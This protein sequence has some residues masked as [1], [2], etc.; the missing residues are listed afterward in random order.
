MGETNLE[1][2]PLHQM[3]PE[4]RFS[5]LV[6]DYAKYRPSYPAAA[7]D[8]ILEGLENRGQLVAADIGAGTG[9]SSR[10]LAQRGVQVI[11]IEPNTQMRQAA[12]THRLVEIRD[13]TAQQTNLPG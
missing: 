4:S 7:I 2:T 3:N 13:G 10:L 8:K 9:I 6:A 11:A 1:T 12:T 5:E